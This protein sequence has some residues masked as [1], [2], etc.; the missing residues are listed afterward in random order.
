LAFGPYV[1]FGTIVKQYKNARMPYDPS[2]MIGTKRR[3]IFGINPDQVYSICTSHIERANLTMRTLMKRFTRLSLGF[4]KKL[5]NM[6]AACALF[7]AYYNWVWRTRYDDKSGQP[8]RLRPTAAM[9]AGVT[10][11]LWHFE[12]LFDAV[13]A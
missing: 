1:K 11:R 9:M 13:T 3:G 10:D 8:G 6:E 4:S 7:F 2:E 5:E 12:D